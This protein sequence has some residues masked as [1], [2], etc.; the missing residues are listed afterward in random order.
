M[1]EVGKVYRIVNN[2]THRFSEGT[3]VLCVYTY[4]SGEGRFTRV[5]A[6][7][8]TRMYHPK[9]DVEEVVLE[10]DFL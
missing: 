4:N 8:G 2:S 6:P 5:L 3:I 1:L 7:S 10:E 9:G